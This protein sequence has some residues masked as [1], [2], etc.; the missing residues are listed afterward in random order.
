MLYYTIL[1]CTILY[2]TILYY[3]ILY[4]TILY[5]TILYYTILYYTILY[6][7]ILYY[8][9]TNTKLKL[10]YTILYYTLLYYTI[11]YY[12]ILYYTILYYTILYKKLYYTILILYSPL[13][14]Y[15][16]TWIPYPPDLGPSPAIL[17]SAGP[18]Q[19]HGSSAARPVVLWVLSLL[20]K[21]CKPWFMFA[22]TALHIH[23]YQDPT[24]TKLYSPVHKTNS[25]PYQVKAH[26]GQGSSLVVSTLAFLLGQCS[27]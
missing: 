23:L 15:I 8:T 26:C 6:Y 5:Y 3:T 20:V 10:Y 27:S 1:H 19:H 2:Y 9:N 24:Q 7:T 11:L 25:G 22:A 14:F 21:S 18:P 4:Y 13:L 12:T 17:I 16:K